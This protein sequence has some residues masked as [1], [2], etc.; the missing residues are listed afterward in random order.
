MVV[1]VAGAACGRPLPDDDPVATG[2]AE[3]GAFDVDEP[4]D[5][6]DAA[7]TGVG[8]GTARAYVL[9]VAEAFRDDGSTAT[10]DLRQ[11]EPDLDALCAGDIDVVAIVGDAD[12][13]VC[14]GTDAAVGFHVANTRGDAIVVYVNRESIRR[15]EL[16]GLIRFALDNAR[17]LPQQAGAQPLGV[18][19]LRETQTKL[20]QIVAEEAG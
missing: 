2:P 14:G 5:D 16:E 15:F 18:E 1:A 6:A 8:S 7:I 4:A 10:L 20:E 9:K 17:T 12:A 19:E 3:T 13:D 11:G